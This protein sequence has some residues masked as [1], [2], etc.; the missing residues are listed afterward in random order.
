[1]FKVAEKLQFAND[2]VPMYTFALPIDLVLKPSTRKIISEEVCII[3]NYLCTS[4]F[5]RI[6]CFAITS[7]IQL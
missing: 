6:I 4:Y 3:D 2:V 1:M 7:I 5:R